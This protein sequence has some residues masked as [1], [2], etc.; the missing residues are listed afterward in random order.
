MIDGASARSLSVPGGLAAKFSGV[1]RPGPASGGW[2][3]ARF[4]RVAASWVRSPL[5]GQ[6]RGSAQLGVYKA[7]RVQLAAMAARPSVHPHFCGPFSSRHNSAVA[8]SA[9]GIQSSGGETYTVVL[10]SAVQIQAF[11]IKP[12]I[13]CYGATVLRS[14]PTLY[15]AYPN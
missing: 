1:R 15:R 12:S 2:V 13:F 10:Q 9:A 6:L 3:R 14:G 8:R 4:G 5:W 11:S 7:L